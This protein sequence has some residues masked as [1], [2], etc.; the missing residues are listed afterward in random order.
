MHGPRAQVTPGDRIDGRYDV[1]ALLGTGGMAVVYRARH[2]GT[3]VPCALKLVHPHLVSRRELVELF[4]KEA[5][6]GGRIGKNPHVVEVF[7][8]GFDPERRVPYLA[9]E[10]L[11]GETLE[12]WCERHGPMPR[13]LV[14]SLFEQLADA[15]SQ[16][17][18]GGV[19]HRDLKP[20]N[21]FLTTGRRGQPRLKV[22]DFGIAKVLEVGAQRTATQIGTPAYAAPEQMG[23][24]MR[25]VAARQGIKV[26]SGVS[27]ATDVW[28]LGLIA[29]ELLTGLPSG[30]FWGAETTVEIPVKA[31]LYPRDSPGARAGDRKKLLPPGFDE[32]FM[33]ATETDAGARWPSIDEAIAGLLAVLAKPAGAPIGSGQTIRGAAPASMS[34]AARAQTIRGA[35]APSALQVTAIDH[36]AARPTAAVDDARSAAPVIEKE[37]APVVVAPPAAGPRVGVDE[38]PAPRVAAIEPPKMPGRFGSRLVPAAAIG[39]ALVVAIGAAGIAP[40]LSARAAREACR[41]SGLRCEEACEAGDAE[42]C[43]LL[44][45]RVERGEEGPRDPV[46]AAALHERACEGGDPAACAALG[47]LVRAG[48]GGQARDPGRAVALFQ[49]ACDGGAPAGCGLLGEAYRDGAGGLARDL[50]RAAALFQSACDRGDLA[51]CKDLGGMHQLGRGGLA[52]DLVRA[53]ALYRRACDGGEL[54]GCSDL[55]VLVGAGRGGHARDER[56]AAELYRKACDG[57]ELL[58]CHN[59]G[60]VYE[61]G[62]GGAPR[63]EARAASLYRRACD[64]GEPRGC[65]SLGAMHEAG[66]G[67]LPLDIA[68]ARSL[69]QDACDAGDPAACRRL[70]GLYE[71]G[72]GGLTRDDARGAEL[73]ARACDG[74]E[75]LACANFGVM[76]S[77]GRGVARD[78]ARALTLYERA[79]DAGVAGGCAG[80]GWALL[81]GQGVPRDRARG[82]ELL[83]RGCDG[84]NAWSCERLRES[85]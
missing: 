74:G 34:G 69:Y 17:H 4:I 44:A 68:R 13:E 53:A 24:A 56:A 54:V 83:R 52:R 35:R 72:K 45:G 16:A 65:G 58:G 64:G 42:G 50:V 78:E 43:G 19:V 75:Q 18:R 55:G 33:K 38:D 11:E 39:V 15:L 8:A 25:D 66:R 36:A 20:S 10:L 12:E 82:L 23:G 28:P 76:L 46:R 73:Y 1:E 60:A 27:V 71:N 61:Q 2:A 79:C 59:L 85:R 62:R 63:D 40:R 32:W 48:R 51:G 9:M 29:Y 47:R 22:M 26:A 3:R 70:G 67:G 81:S 21:L 14:V 80:L 37:P 5:R 84:G 49:R 57:G 30:Q 77:T 6:V 7:D 31:V 41:A